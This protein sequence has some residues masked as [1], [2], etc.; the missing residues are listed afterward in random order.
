MGWYGPR[1]GDCSCCG[2]AGCDIFD[3]E[4][5]RT[6]STPG[7]DWTVVW[8]GGFAPDGSKLV[9]LGDGLLIAD[10]AH[11]D[12]ES[13]QHVIVR[14]YAGTNRDKCR[15]V[16]DYSDSDNYH[17]VEIECRGVAQLRF[18]K[19]TA[20][21]ASQI[22][23]TETVDAAGQA[24]NTFE[25]CFAEDL[26]GA[27]VDGYWYTRDTTKHGGFQVGLGCELVGFTNTNYTT[28]R[29]LNV[30]QD[31]REELA[32]VVCT[33]I[34]DVATG[35][36]NGAAYSFTNDSNQ[37][38]IACNRCDTV[39][40][41]NVVA[42]FVKAN[43]G[44][45][46]TTRN[47]NCT[48]QATDRDLDATSGSTEDIAD[49]FATFVEAFAWFDDFDYDKGKSVANPSCPECKEPKVDCSYCSE[50][51]IYEFW[52]VTVS[53]MANDDCT[54]CADIDGTYVIQLDGN[55]QGDWDAAY[56][57]DIEPCAGN[58]ETGDNICPQPIAPPSQ[59]DV[60]NLGLCYNSGTSHYWL[61]VS[62]IVRYGDTSPY[63]YYFAHDCGTSKPTCGD[64]DGLTI[65]YSANNCTPPAYCPCDG[66]SASVELEAIG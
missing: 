64:F 18:Y 28:R 44:T 7:A 4:F 45:T 2:P 38:S 27:K 59:D 8:G 53:G 9:V 31:S 56:C 49:T 23:D 14:F 51:E 60:V 42:T 58:T 35:N 47:I 62:L 10:D 52:R 12:S 37:T 36:Y 46:I 40:I 3:D 24:W 25:A 11:P 63:Y 55:T 16:L 1:T 26:I 30:T 66:S 5:T 57:N 50:G 19:V 6:D 54:A 61:I 33:L 15:I 34:N 48:G 22:G 20:G 32:D 41:G 65:N 29:S 43:S 39:E 13:Y 17:Y 21:V